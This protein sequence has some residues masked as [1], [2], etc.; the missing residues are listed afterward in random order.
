[1]DGAEGAEPLLRSL[2]TSVAD[3]DVWKELQLTLHALMPAARE[4]ALELVE[5]APEVS[6]LQLWA[7]EPCAPLDHPRVTAVAESD[8]PA[9]PFARYLRSPRC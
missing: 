9:A 5:A 3:G 7:L 1:M 6:V 2:A 4:L 8:T